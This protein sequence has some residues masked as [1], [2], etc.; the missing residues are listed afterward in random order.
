VLVC[1][2][3]VIKTNL[4]LVSST[5]SMTRF[6]FLIKYVM[7]FAGI[8]KSFVADPFRFIQILFNIALLLLLNL[9]VLLYFILYLICG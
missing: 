4:L 9:M 1:I 7:V 6:S 3:P 2:V 8:S 5:V